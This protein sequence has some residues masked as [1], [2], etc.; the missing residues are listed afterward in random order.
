M[1]IK[2]ASVFLAFVLSISFAISALADQPST[3]AVADG[4]WNIIVENIELLSLSAVPEVERKVIFDNEYTWPKTEAEKEELIIPVGTVISYQAGPSPMTLAG[5]FISK[6]F[7]LD[8]ENDLEMYTEIKTENGKYYEDEDGSIDGEDVY[9]YPLDDF[10]ESWPPTEVQ[11]KTSFT[12]KEPGMYGVKAVYLDNNEDEFPGAIYLVIRVVNS[13]TVVETEK[14]SSWAET[15]INEAIVSNLVPQNLRSNYTQATTRAEF[16]ALA[17]ALYENLSGEIIERT[18]FL[19]TNDA[20]VEKMAALGVVNGIGDDKFAPDDNL[21]REQAAVMLA[22]LAD[23]IGNP[24]T[25]HPPTFSDI[26]GIS[27]W[28]IEGV[29][30]VQNAGIMGGVGDNTFAPLDD[31]TREQSIVTMLRLYETIQ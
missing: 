2:T 20:N 31:Y 18:M 23:S 16:C 30:Q 28:A 29:G 4:H 12:F 14:P 10:S 11:K 8:N 7:Y 17:V 22:R 25:M 5:L 19:D 9:S 21:T 26:D 13:S 6:L 3:G 1:K 27:L 24:F 15:S